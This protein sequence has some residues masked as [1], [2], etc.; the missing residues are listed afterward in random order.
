MKVEDR[1]VDDE[2]NQQRKRDACTFT[3]GRRHNPDRNRTEPHLQILLS[4]QSALA[5]HEEAARSVFAQCA[6]FFTFCRV[7]ELCHA[8]IRQDRF[9]FA[10]LGLGIFV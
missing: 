3:L 4:R 10:K 5:L 8:Q 2:A 9:E 7:S 6:D 1:W